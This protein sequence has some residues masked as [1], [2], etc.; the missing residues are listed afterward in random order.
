MWKDINFWMEWICQKNQSALLR[1]HKEIYVVIELPLG[2]F[3]IIETVS[4]VNANRGESIAF[5]VIWDIKPS[6]R[7]LLPSRRYA[8]E[9]QNVQFDR[10]HELQICTTENCSFRNWIA[11][12]CLGIV[13]NG[14]Q[15]DTNWQYFVYNVQII[16]GGDPSQ[17]KVLNA[18]ITN[19][20]Y[21]IIM[22]LWVDVIESCAHFVHSAT[23]RIIVAIVRDCH[24]SITVSYR[25]H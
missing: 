8:C 22:R 15:S 10:N 1:L 17:V 13:S 5:R 4:M 21:L 14:I 7:L 19:S 6:R 23:R 20:H 3:R 11:M 9:R 25:R 24:L 18:R 16:N 2:E 12:M